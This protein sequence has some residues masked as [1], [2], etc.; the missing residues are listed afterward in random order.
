MDDLQKLIIVTKFTA[1]TQPAPKP[2]PVPK[3]T[4]EPPDPIPPR[5]HG[6]FWRGTHE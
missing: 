6:P 3:P 1:P 2:E 4:P 5:D